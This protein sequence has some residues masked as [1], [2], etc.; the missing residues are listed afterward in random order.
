VTDIN[1]FDPRLAGTPPFPAG[2]LVE[3]V[4]PS[5][6]GWEVTAAQLS[7]LQMSGPAGPQ[8]IQ[9]PI[10]LTGPA[11]PAG[12]TGPQ[13][14]PGAVGAVGATGPA[15]P[16][17]PQGIPGVP[18]AV[19]PAGL[20]GQ[21]GASGATG[22]AGPAGAPG[23]STML[24]QITIDWDS[25]TVVAA[26][27][28]IALLASQW[29]SATILSATCICAGGTFTAAILVNGAA[30]TGLSAIAVSSTLATDPATNGTVATRA[31]ITVTISGV[32]G[33]PTSAAIQI[34]LQTSAN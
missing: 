15:G 19:G 28:F 20:Q 17:G 27:T 34:N 31:S 13:G 32:T 7:D 18:G 8:G 2:T 1:I 16:A 25:N 14:T 11:G 10:G 30:V 4:V 5:A 22:P 21:P 24:Q 23:P 29:T 9:G 12:P 26:G 33:T 3:V 6:A